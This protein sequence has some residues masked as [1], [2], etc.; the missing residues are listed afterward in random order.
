MKGYINNY[1]FAELECMKYYA[2]PATWSE[3]KIKQETRNRIFSG[4]WFGSQKRDGALY[5]FLKDEDGNITLRGRSKGVSGEYLDK[6]DHLPQLKEWADSLPNGC[7]FLGEVYRPGN[8]GSKVTT[9]VMGCATEKAIARQQ[10]EEDKMHYYIFDVLAYDGSSYMHCY[11]LQRFTKLE[12]LHFTNPSP[13]VEYAVYV[14]GDELWDTLQSLL[15][16]GYEGMVITH[17]D[18]IY[19]PGKRPSKTTLKVKQ[20]LRQTID[21]IIIGSNPATRDYNGK[22]IEVW[23]YWYNVITDEKLPVGIYYQDWKRGAPIIPVTK[24]FYNGWAGSLRLGLVRD[25]EV[26]YFGDLSG[27]TEEIL[28]NPKDYIGKVAEVGGMQIDKESHHIRH[29][30]FLGWRTDKTPRECDWVQ[31]LD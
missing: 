8:A 2:P 30:R 23:T 31:V 24:G 11:A 20:S 5:V 28:A 14:S 16:Q 4:E 15:A 25:N 6:W 18:A 3:E 27:L 22:N 1:N 13:Y 9:T 21:C 26:I 17:K 19:E 10:K 29:P 7:C 12:E